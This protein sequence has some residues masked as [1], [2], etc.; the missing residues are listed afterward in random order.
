GGG[1]GREVLRGR[2]RPRGRGGAG[3]APDHGGALGVSAPPVPDELNDR[4]ADNWR[5]LFAIAD[6]AG[7]L[8][9]DLARAAARTMTGAAVEADPAAPVQLLAGLQDLFATTAGDKLTTAAI[10]RHLVTPEQLP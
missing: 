5:P 4:Q 8:W 6:A 7:G 3:G 9:S 1:A 2:V 10:L